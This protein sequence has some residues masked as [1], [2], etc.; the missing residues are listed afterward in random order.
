MSLSLQLLHILWIMLPG[1]MAV[2]AAARTN[3]TQAVRPLPGSNSVVLLAMVPLIALIA[4]TV[5]SVVSEISKLIYK[6]T[7]FG[8]S[9]SF[10]PNLAALMIGGSLQKAGGADGLIAMYVAVW[11][12]A[13]AVIGYFCP[14]AGSYILKL[15]RKYSDKKPEDRRL[16]EHWIDYLIRS[17]Q[18]DY[19][20]LAGFVVTTR[21]ID[22]LLLGYSGPVERIKLDED[23][24]PLEVTLLDSIPFFLGEDGQRLEYFNDG[25]EKLPFITFSPENIFS[26]SLEIKDE[27]K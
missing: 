5:L 12:L 8:L 25:M 1:L 6:E 2:I 3:P 10:D 14:F 11:L 17:V 23:G 22:G 13:A 4:H 7:G 20:Y 15:I 26:I 9:L 19:N 24:T 18:P 27:K 21:E 16:G